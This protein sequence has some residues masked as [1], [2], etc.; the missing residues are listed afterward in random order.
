V[1]FCTFQVAQNGK[2]QPRARIL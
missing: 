2:Q 1:L